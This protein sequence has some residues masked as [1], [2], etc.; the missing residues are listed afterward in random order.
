MEQVQP[1][2]VV[3]YVTPATAVTDAHAS[4]VVE[5][6]TPAPT[7]GVSSY[8]KNSGANSLPNSDSADLETETHTHRANCAEARGDSTVANLGQGY[9]ACSLLC[10]DMCPWS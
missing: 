5:H 4:P 8:H 10:N 9:L 7:V 2:P 3:E 1:A 6:V